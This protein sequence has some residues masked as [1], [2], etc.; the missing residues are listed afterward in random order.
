[1]KTLFLNPFEKYSD[2]IL[3]ITGLLFSTFAVLLA[4][5]FNARFDGFLDLHFSDNTTIY[6]SLS[7][8][9][10]GIISG[11]IVFFGIGRLINKKTRLIDILSTCLIA[12]IPFYISPLLNIN[13]FMYNTTSRVVKIANPEN[14]HKI[15]TTDIIIL[16]AT[17]TLTLLTLIWMIALLFNGFKIAT[18]SKETKHTLFFIAGII[19]AEIV[20]KIVISQITL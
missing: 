14:V 4:Y 11:T 6:Q 3:L 10:I 9:L 19:I 17:S 8:V 2:R 15:S 18:N 7:D 5:T 13:G 16:M 20:S 1:M 12:K